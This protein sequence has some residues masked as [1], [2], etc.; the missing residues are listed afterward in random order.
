MLIGTVFS[1]TSTVSKDDLSVQVAG[2]CLAGQDRRFDLQSLVGVIR[3]AARGRR[4]VRVG[5]DEALDEERYWQAHP[6]R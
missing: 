4:I 1:P 2:I 3:Q 6:P 5:D